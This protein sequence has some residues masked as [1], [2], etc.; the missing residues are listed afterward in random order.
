MKRSFFIIVSLLLL[1]LIVAG[2]K[3]EPEYAEAEEFSFVVYPGARYLVSR[4]LRQ[5]GYASLEATAGE[6][7][8]IVPDGIDVDVD[9]SIR[10][11]G[12]IEVDG[13]IENGNGVDLNRRIDGG[14]DVSQLYLEL[15]LVVGDA[16][17]RG[18]PDEIAEREDRRDPAVV[19]GL[20]TA[21]QYRA[22]CVH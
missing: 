10:L 6:I 18:A 5:S 21:A 2:C 9:G 4:I 17:L 16:V 22:C 14:D 7:L 3:Q 13:V 19:R 12:E 11:G 1:A 8:V 20:L 15:D